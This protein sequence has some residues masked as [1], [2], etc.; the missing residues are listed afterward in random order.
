MCRSRSSTTPHRLR[1]KGPNLVINS[2]ATDADARLATA[3]TATAAQHDALF[4]ALQ[5]L[6]A[7]LMGCARRSRWKRTWHLS[8]RDTVSADLTGAVLRGAGE[9]YAQSPAG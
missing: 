5:V 1:R 9:A 7:V 3:E 8:Q 6:T 2:A 4:S